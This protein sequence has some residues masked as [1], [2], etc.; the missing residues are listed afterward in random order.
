MLM[1]YTHTPPARRS[2]RILGAA[3]EPHAVRQLLAALGLAAEP[4]RAGTLGSLLPCPF[5]VVAVN[6]QIGPPVSSFTRGSRRVTRDDAR[7]WKHPGIV[8]FRGD[9]SVPTVAGGD[10]ARCGTSMAPGGPG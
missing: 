7:S 2:R 6:E 4:S 1:H 5:P 9:V 10:D 8:G 3:A